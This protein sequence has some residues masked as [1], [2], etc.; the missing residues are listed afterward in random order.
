[1]GI[2]FNSFS[3][4]SLKSINEAVFDK[5]HGIVKKTGKGLTSINRNKLKSVGYRLR[6]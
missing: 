3:S 6:K 5:H 1:M 2:I 4:P